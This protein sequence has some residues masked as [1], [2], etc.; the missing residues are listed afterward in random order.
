MPHMTQLILVRHGQ[1]DWNVEGRYQGQTDRPLNAAGR[2]QAEALAR[3]L[4]PGQF[5]AIYSSDLLRA[6]ETAQIIATGLGL[7]VQVDRRLREINLGDWE[8]RQVAE[9]A[10]QYQ[11]AWADRARDPGRSRAP[12]GETVAEVAARLADAAAHIAR[13]HPGGTVVVVSH[14]VALATLICQARQRPLAE[15]Y[16]LI[17]DNGRTEAIDWPPSR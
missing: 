2:A 10:A 4:A 1:T 12:G 9:I 6:L 16:S 7:P 5:A 13:R 11:G 14:G 15:A 3:Q 17:P 8:G